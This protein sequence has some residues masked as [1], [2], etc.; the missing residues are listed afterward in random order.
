MAYMKSKGF[1]DYE[2]FYKWSLENRFEYWDD[3]AKGLHWFEPWQQTFQ[4]TTKPFFQWFTGGKTNI[5]L[6]LP[7][8]AYENTSLDKVAYHWEGD[9]RRNSHADLQRTLRDGQPYGERAAK[10]RRWQR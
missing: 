1:E 4:W 3:M 10:S 5:V 6:Q 2:K 9:E 7:R 8:P